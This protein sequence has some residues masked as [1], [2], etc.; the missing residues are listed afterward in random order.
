MSALATA[1]VFGRPMEVVS[2][3]GYECTSNVIDGQGMV[4]IVTV[5]GHN[6]GRL[7]GVVMPTDQIL[8]PIARPLIVEEDCDICREMAPLQCDRHA[9]R[10]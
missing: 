4:A 6:G 10:I 8:L 2:V 5:R 7:S 3:D 9:G 1:L